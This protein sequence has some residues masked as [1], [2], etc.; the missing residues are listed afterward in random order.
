M[1]HDD[2]GTNFGRILINMIKFLL[3]SSIF[4]FGTT[5]DDYYVKLTQAT[6]YTL[7]QKQ[8]KNCSII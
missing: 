1:I 3:T 6:S 2:F 7:N 8:I 5:D 4:F